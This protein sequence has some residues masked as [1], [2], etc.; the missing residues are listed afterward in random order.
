M[1][2]NPLP[3]TEKKTQTENNWLIITV[4]MYFKC[5]PFLCRRFGD[6]YG[7][8]GG[9]VCIQRVAKIQS[10]TH[11]CCVCILTVEDTNLSQLL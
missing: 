5:F 8:L 6:P 9:S 1:F 3:P 10:G 2:P 7:R 11:K 4:K